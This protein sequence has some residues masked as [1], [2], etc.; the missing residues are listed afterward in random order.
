VLHY[1]L[2]PDKVERIDPVALSPRDF[3][4]EWLEEPWEQSRLRS[5]PTARTALEK[6]HTHARLD[7]FQPTKSC[8][9]PE[10][11]QV[12]LGSLDGKTAPV[13]YL[14]RWRPPY[15]FTMMGA[16]RR[17]SPDCT[18]VDPTADDAERT[19]FPVQD[20]RE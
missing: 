19:L 11:W 20:W 2:T 17:P 8:R 14:V 13:Y 1:S 18:T 10:I 7:E 9:T 16:S 4:D 6:A 5:E 12:G 3:V 15:H